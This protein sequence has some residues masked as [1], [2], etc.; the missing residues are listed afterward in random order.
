[1]NSSA[2]QRSN[3][4]AVA[5]R[6]FSGYGLTL[7]PVRHTDIRVLRRW[8]NSPAISQQMTDTTY[9]SPHQ[10]RCWY[11]HIQ[12]TSNEFHWVA[13]FRNERAGY[14]NLKWERSLDGESTLGGGLYVGDSPVRHGLLGY[15][16][17]LMQLRIAFSVLQAD[18]YTTR[19]RVHNQSAEKFNKQLGYRVCSRDDAFVTVEITP[20]E[21]Q[22]AEE[23]LRRYFKRR[24]A[25]NNTK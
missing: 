19:F 3:S 6:V 25:A 5:K 14:M 15:A 1:M 18:C 4:V 21:Y 9:I 17:A 12:S 11:E 8:R 20:S 10:Q 23:R 16:L 24:G 13:W 2:A 7:F 22:K